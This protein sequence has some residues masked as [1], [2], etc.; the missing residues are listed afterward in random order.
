[1]SW[2]AR[3]WLRLTKESTY[4]TFNASP[5]AG[6]Q[7]YI[8]LTGDNPFTVMPKP[9]PFEIV[10]CDA[11][12]ET[13]Q[14]DNQIYFTDGNLTTPAYPSQMA[15]FLSQLTGAA[16][17]GTPAVYA[18]PSFTA[19]YYDGARTRRYLGCHFQTGMLAVPA[20]GGP[21]TWSL[22]IISWKP[23][24][25]NPT[26]TEPALSSFPS[27]LPLRLQ[28]TVSALKLATSDATRTK[29]NA[30][31]ATWTN[32]I[33]REPDETAYPSLL[34][35]GRRCAFQGVFHYLTSETDRALYEARTTT[36]YNQITFT[37]TGQH[38]VLLNWNG[39]GKVTGFSPNYR[40]AGRNY[41]TLDMVAL[42]DGAATPNASFAY[43][44]TAP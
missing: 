18:L 34:Y 24:S 2:G 33:A 5:S 23:D 12:G 4:G 15:F 26:F 28:D 31:S 39:K 9:Q 37:R 44:V 30:F 42:Y 38:T 7:I 40:M 10:S 41:V 19:D 8:R 17:S 22:A 29:Y 20:S 16:G 32:N 6:E 1:M 3:Q 43:T 21:A 36:T 11:I 14:E 35:A 27:D 13:V 25:S